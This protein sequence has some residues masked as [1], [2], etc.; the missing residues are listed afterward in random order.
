MKAYQRLI[1]ERDGIVPNAGLDIGSA[2]V[3]AITPAVARA[4]LEQHEYLRTM[5]AMVRYCYGLFFADRLAGVVVYATE[6]SE[7]L[8][9]WDRYGYTGKL[10]TLAR[11]ACL[12]WAHPHAASKLIRASMKLL[13]ARYEVITATVDSAAV[14]S[15]YQACGFHYVGVMSP[16]GRIRAEVSERCCRS[17]YGTANKAKLKRKGLRV[18]TVPRKARYFA[19]RGSRR[20]QAM[21]LEAIKHLI[22]PYPKRRILGQ[23]LIG[24]VGGAAGPGR[25]KRGQIVTRF[26]R[27]NSRAYTLARLA[28]DHPELAIRVHAGE[29]SAHAAA[30]EAGWRKT[31][32]PGMRSTCARGRRSSSAMLPPSA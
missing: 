7:N 12:P 26:Q 19:F 2:Q 20:Q 18:K 17:K 11:G 15:I 30:I 32:Q 8:G 9:V 22:K 6:T 29:L 27:G 13:P 24:I 14:G 10:L 21:L 16:G 4:V 31:T 23:R 1:R 3:R 25:G 28:R 5:P